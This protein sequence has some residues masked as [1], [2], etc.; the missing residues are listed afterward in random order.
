MTTIR[1]S[2]IVLAATLVFAGLTAHVRAADQKPIEKLTGATNGAARAAIPTLDEM[3]GEWLPMK[4]VDNPPAVHNFNDL[5]LFYR[6]KGVVDLTSFT[7][8]NFVELG[9]PGGLLWCDNPN[10]IY[11]TIRLLI[12]GTNHPAVEC[13]WVPYRAL[14]RN[15]DCT[16]LSVETDLRMINE[17]YGVLCRVRVT[18][19]GTTPRKTTL[20]LEVTGGLQPDGKAVLTPFINSNNNPEHKVSYV[21]ATCV[22]QKP[23]AVSGS[24]GV[25]HWNWTVTLP[26][27]GSRV[28][29]FVSGHG[30]ENQTAAIVAR[31]SD[32]A[33][34]FAAE[35]DGCK[36]N[37]EQRWADAFTP[38]NKH[39]SGNL[40]V[41]ATD[42]A[43]LKRN[44]YMGVVTM[45]ILERTQFAIH[46]RSFITSGERGPG[47]QF[48]WDATMQ[49][50]AWA[51]LE[52]DGMKAVL[53]RWLAQ[54]IR[55]SAGISLDSTSGYRKDKS[56]QI[57][58]YAFTACNF[59]QGILDY[60]RV[61]RDPAFL[62]EKLESG[63]TVMERLDEIAIDW[64]GLVLPDSPLANYGENGNLLEC[65]PAYIHRVASLNAQAVWMIRQAAL[66]HELRNDPVRA[67]ELR[68]DAARLLP[69][70]LDLYKPGDGVWYGLHKDGK[71]VEL[72][73]CVDYIYVGNA[74]L[75]DLTPV[76]RK[77][78]TDF[79]K[80]EL[81]MRDWMRAM[82]QKDAAAANSD[83][84]DH[85][86]MGAY[87]G[88]IPLTVGTMWRLGFP[89]DAFE[90]YCRTAGVT[91]EG[92]FAQ[93][94]EFY[95]P[96]RA[97]Y[98]APVRVAW[99]EGCL[100]ECISGVAFADVVI[101]T[102][103]G[104]SP[105]L[106]GKTI[107]ADPKT[108][109]PFQ[110]T[111]TGVRYGNQLYKLTAGKSGVEAVNVGKK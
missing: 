20:T 61:T 104:F 60:V 49:A 72:R 17:Q 46:P 28:L 89:K 35:F 40:P 67:K 24:N 2:T 44:Y 50:T 99:R 78:M 90:F 59:F 23:D 86:P 39:F 58:G 15:N 41:L 25:V 68:G 76:M 82:S 10:K 16:G 96:N 52:P 55:A 32:W 36:K 18:N 107:I 74:L 26:P 7:T 9:N 84:P 48:F 19:P 110:G 1:N 42:N 21:T 6:D 79:V 98:D 5:V 87:D 33:G 38:G 95:G 62:D 11:P 70:V 108:P 13:R 100:K 30:P 93:A 88:W 81:F 54:N 3:A 75:N 73:H 92:P 43:A 37:W 14:R 53:K 12:D 94:H 103:F 106:D 57:T 102:F 34:K 63:Q 91:K 31:V 85:G 45:L 22:T 47:A 65:A 51:L 4:N 80:R 83:R 97:D 56:D 69:A 64:K 77:E 109:R 29:E 66:L 8:G 27:G 101:N 111:L 105:S 71:R